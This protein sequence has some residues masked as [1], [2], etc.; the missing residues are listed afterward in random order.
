MKADTLANVLAADSGQTGEEVL[1][2][3]KLRSYADGSLKAFLPWQTSK[4]IIFET[5][6]TVTKDILTSIVTTLAAVAI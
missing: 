3:G 6:A 1:S 4:T 5:K 2:D